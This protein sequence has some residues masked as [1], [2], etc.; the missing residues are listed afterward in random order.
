L[1]E[2]NQRDRFYVFVAR[3]NLGRFR[4]DQE[5]FDFIGVPDMPGALRSVWE[6]NCSAAGAGAAEDRAP[7]FASLFHRALG[8]KL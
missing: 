1:A 6:Q 5:N 4:L 7:A 2:T 3:K 8:E